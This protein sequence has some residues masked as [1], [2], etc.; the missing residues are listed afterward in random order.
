[1]RPDINFVWILLCCLCWAP[2]LTRGRVCLLSGTVSN[3]CP[4]SSFIFFL[5]SPTFYT[6][7]ILCIC[8]ICKV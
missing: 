5:F 8:N 1:L 4:S 7:H 3:N 2:S 6:S